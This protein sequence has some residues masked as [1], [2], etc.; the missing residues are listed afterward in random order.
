M[1]KKNRK[2]ILIQIDPIEQLNAKTDSSLLLAKEALKRGHFVM[3][4]NPLDLNIINN[5]II[6]TV[7]QLKLDKGKIKY[8]CSSESNIEI[9]KFDIILI[10]QDPPFDMKYITN[11]Y[12]IDLGCIRS[13]KKFPF[14]VNNPTGI[15]SFTEKIFPLIFE[16]IIPITCITSN[17]KIITNFLKK[18][19][20]IV[21]KP[22]YEKGGD[23]IFMVQKDD[24][25]MLSI[26]SSATNNFSEQI[27][28]QEYLNEVSKGDKRVILIDGEPVGAVNRIP[29]K[30][31]F[32]ANLHLGGTPKK[33]ILSK[34]ELK[35]C[36]L[37]KPFLKKNGFFFVGI[38][39]I[40][41]KLTEINVTSP[42]GISQINKLNNTNLE[43]IFWKKLEQK[44]N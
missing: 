13:T 23:G 25:N 29:S 7:K 1:N 33:T 15:R 8:I 36:S 35:I 27:I 37:I 21:I 14:I 44:F 24:P 17:P 10:R 5:K 28:L 42:T 22:L 30:N 12:L 6:V 26:I 18:Y 11:T 31:N 41:E 3:Y 32:K 34:K 20:K 16:D 9:S 4:S 19:K 40:G 43:S 39:I 38:D 2:K